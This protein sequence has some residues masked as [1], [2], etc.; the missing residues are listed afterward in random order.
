MGKNFKIQILQENGEFKNASLKPREVQFIQNM[1]IG[2]A[3]TQTFLSEDLGEKRLRTLCALGIFEKMEKPHR[4]EVDGK[5]VNRHWYTLGEN[6][7]TLAK[8]QEFCGVLQGANGYKHAEKMERVVD[9]LLINKNID[10]RNIYNEKD[11]KQI[12]KKELRKLRADKTKYH[13]N[14]IAYKDSFGGWHSVEVVTES[15]GKTLLKKHEA[16]ASAIGATYEKV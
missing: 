10:I 4:E 13:I 12:F 6:G 15:Y 2:G 8:D 16:F 5:V 14:D 7:K 3:C 11:Q 9:D 1:C